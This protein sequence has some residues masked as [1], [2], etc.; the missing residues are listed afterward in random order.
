MI[1]EITGIGRNSIM[2]AVGFLTII[3]GM[4][5]AGDYFNTSTKTAYV[6]SEEL[7]NGFQGKKE[8]EVKLEGK[9]HEYREYLDSLKNQAFGD[10]TL[11]KGKLIEMYY[12][13]QTELSQRERQ[14]SID[15]TSKIW[16][17]LN[18]YIEQYGRQNNYDFILGTSGSGNV[19]YAKEEKDITEFILKYANEQYEGN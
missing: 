18:E 8:L 17:R 11:N 19:M 6:N 2:K 1:E 10:T 4:F 12:Q 14:L 9:K 5:F 15:Y 7:F 16:M 3:G 13:T